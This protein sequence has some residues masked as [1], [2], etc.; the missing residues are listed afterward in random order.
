MHTLIE[1][2]LG[3]SA[4]YCGGSWL[5]YVFLSLRK[6]YGDDWQ[7]RMERYTFHLGLCFLLAIG[8]LGLMQGAR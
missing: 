5:R 8:F 7:D 2:L 6:I 4:L 3:L 1:V